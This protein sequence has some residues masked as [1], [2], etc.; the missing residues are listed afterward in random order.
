MFNDSEIIDAR[1]KLLALD[2]SQAVIQFD[3][4]GH[5]VEANE[6]FLRLFEYELDQIVGCHHSIFC[7]PDYVASKAYKEFW[8]ALASG[9]SDAGQ[10]KRISRSGREVWIQSSYNPVLDLQG[11][12]IKVIKFA[13]DISEQKSA[14]QAL[15]EA[16]QK[17]DAAL[18]SKEQFLST[19]S[20]EL[21]TPMNVI[22]G[23]GHLL[24][25]E[26]TLLPEHR[27]QVDEIVK[28][29]GHLL[30]LI[31]D[32]L[33]LTQVESGLTSLRSIPVRLDEIA[34]DALKMI[35]VVARSRHVTVMPF[36]PSGLLVRADPFRLKQVLVNL[37]SNAVKYNRAQGTVRLRV[38]PLE[39]MT[40]IAV[41]DDGLGIPSSK[42]DQ[43][44]QP[45]NRLGAEQ[46][47][48]EGTGIGLS[49]CKR[50]VDAMQGSISVTSTEGLGSTFSIELPSVS[51]M[52]TEELRPHV[53]KGIDPRPSRPSSVAKVRILVAEDHIVN[54][55]LI[56]RQLEL[57]GYDCVV[58][59]N[60]AE[61]LHALS[62]TSESGFS[63]LLSDINM[64]VMD[65][66]ALA[67][68]LRR[69]GHTP[70][71]LP[72]VFLT[73][74]VFNADHDHWKSCGGNAYLTKPTQM[75]ALSE[76]LRQFLSPA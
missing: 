31:N 57:L 34:H 65:G 73:A 16:K 75:E 66:Y 62:G 55:K 28:A 3:L 56:R 68:A 42:M 36:E 19:M 27:E 10:Y 47:E 69:D 64:P 14:Q 13:T 29:G 54:Q 35:Q 23:L 26:P 50:M 15:A 38:T 17:A 58:V 6:N 48:V 8:S 32:V 49:I 52:I 9:R 11:R 22:I 37:L 39:G 45:F 61:A 76:C 53:S 70:E 44:F 18:R 7:E 60:G 20:H 41:E 72:I 4:T 51:A 33:D 2:R 46:T 21:R 74:D 12:P 25:D 30:S 63:L 43:L 24:M 71:R 1:G 40:R 67:S 59:S 5:V